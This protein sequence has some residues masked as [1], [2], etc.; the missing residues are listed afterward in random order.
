MS[1]SYFLSLFFIFLANNLPDRIL[2]H[3]F[4][5]KINHNNP[6][7]TDYITHYFR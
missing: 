1:F 5:R 3:K 6:E 7:K 4:N 2:H